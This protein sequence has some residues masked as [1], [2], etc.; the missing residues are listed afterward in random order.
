MMKNFVPK[1]PIYVVGPTASGK[2]EFAF[3]LAKRFDGVIISADSMQIY[4]KLDVGTAKDSVERRNEV[5][6]KLV[7]VVNAD[8]EFSVAEFAEIAKKEIK[9]V[10]NCGKLPI[11]VGGTGLYFESLFYPMSFGHTAKNPELRAKLDE[12]YDLIG[13]EKMLAKLALI[14]EDA[15]KKLYPNDKKRIVRALE[16]ALSGEKLKSQQDDKKENPDVIAIGFNT[17]RSVLYDRINLRVDKMFDEGLASEV[18]D[19]A[20][21]IENAF[22]KQAF[23][24]IGYKEFAD[25]FKTSNGKIEKIDDKSLFEVKELIK[26]NTRNYAKRQLTWFRRYDFV[27]WFECGDFENA[28]A[29]VEN[30]IESRQ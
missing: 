26:K 27:K 29:F 28:I 17:E 25:V 21:E 30:E 14:D 12:E 18:F 16:I 23:K 1:E 2:S 8:E 6:Y 15:A 3:Q 19:V 4:K 20:N 5:D 22:E 7:D 24:A 11:V 13:G 10:L 9:N